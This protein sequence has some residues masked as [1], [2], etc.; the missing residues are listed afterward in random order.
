MYLYVIGIT[1]F[2]DTF[3]KI[4]YSEVTVIETE[5]I[6]IMLDELC[7]KIQLWQSYQM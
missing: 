1:R 3:S 2:T 6:K 7:R 4:D 5:T